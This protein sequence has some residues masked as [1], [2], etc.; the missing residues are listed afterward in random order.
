MSFS[1]T[2]TKFLA[3]EP[4]FIPV[5]SQFQYLEPEL[6]LVRE[7]LSL[8]TAVSIRPCFAR[9]GEKL[10]QYEAEVHDPLCPWFRQYLA[11]E[12]GHEE[13]SLGGQ[14]IARLG[15]DQNVRCKML[16]AMN[17]GNVVFL[18]PELGQTYRLLHCLNDNS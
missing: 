17:K 14:D 16:E 1:H 9:R 12:L 5:D 7:A 2:L 6:E 4:L 3:A 8:G 13:S 15:A 10:M 11:Y 18:L